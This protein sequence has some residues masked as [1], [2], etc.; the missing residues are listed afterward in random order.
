MFKTGVILAAG[1]GKRMQAFG[2]FNG[3]K[4]LLPLPGG[5]TIVGRIANSMKACDRIICAI[6]EEAQIAAFERAFSNL[7]RPVEII[8]KKEAGEFTEIPAIAAAIPEGNVI[9]T[10]GDLIFDAGVVEDFIA[11]NG[12]RDFFIRGREGN[13]GNQRG[14]WDFFNAR[15][16]VVPARDFAK[17]SPAHKLEVICALAKSLLLGRVVKV[18]TLFNVDT[19]GDYEAACAYFRMRFDKAKPSNDQRVVS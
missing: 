8:V 13:P 7:S 19:P 4:Q 18:P 3:P 14:V 10:N 9:H 5:E 15:I 12:D 17:F 2:G 1:E 11:R 16:S 6:R